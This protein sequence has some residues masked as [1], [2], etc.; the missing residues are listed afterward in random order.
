LQQGQRL[1]NLRLAD[2]G[3]LEVPA[4]AVENVG[5]HVLEPMAAEARHD[6]AVEEPRVVAL[7][8][9]REVRDHVQLEPVARKLGE[10]LVGSLQFTELAKPLPAF[11]LDLEGLRVRLALEPASAAGRPAAGL[12]VADAAIGEGNASS[13]HGTH[14]TPSSGPPPKFHGDRDMLEIHEAFM[15][16]ACAVICQRYLRAL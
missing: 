6:V 5:P 10:V 12:V 2:T 16:L 1:A 4:E 13:S 9:A 15:S 11:D 14:S 7:G 8:A 3:F